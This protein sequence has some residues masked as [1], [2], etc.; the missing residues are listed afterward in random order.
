MET[1]FCLLQKIIKEGLETLILS[2]K[3]LKKIG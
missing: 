1:G 2:K 3:S